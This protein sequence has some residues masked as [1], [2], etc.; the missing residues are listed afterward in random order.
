MIFLAMSQSNECFH[1]IMQAFGVDTFGHAPKLRQ[2][3]IDLILLLSQANSAAAHLIFFK[4]S[5][6]FEV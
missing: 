2:K 4:A 3:A 5:T 6:S 1:L